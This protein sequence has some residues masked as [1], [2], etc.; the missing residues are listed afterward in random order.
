MAISRKVRRV[1]RAVLKQQGIRAAVHARVIPRLPTAAQRALPDHCIIGGQKCGTTSLDAYLRHHPNVREGLYKEI[2]FFDL[3]FDKG[4]NWYRA[5]FPTRASMD[6]ASEQLGG[7]VVTGESTPSYLF[8]PLVP[9]RMRETIPSVRLIAILR[10][11]VDRA[12]SHWQQIR[13]WN[14]ERLPFEEAIDAEAERLPQHPGS[15]TDL[16]RL[17]DYLRFSYLARGRYAEQLTRWFEAF[18]RDQLLI[19]SF[20]DLRTDTDAVCRQVTDFL[21][22][23]EFR[24]DVFPKTASRPR[25]KMAP[26]TRARLRE[27]FRPYNQ[28]L[29]ELLGRD[30]GWDT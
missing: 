19:L 17:D 30:L 25:A 6:R 29:Y 24:M 14:E 21:E 20:D 13:D 26:E 3:H 4:L 5:H 2:H 22:L 27:Y 15:L 11:P 8:H 23:T 1:V 10:N 12:H 9:Q 18:P 16:R 28:R 7:R